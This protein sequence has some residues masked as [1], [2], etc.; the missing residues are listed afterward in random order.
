MHQSES[1]TCKSKWKYYRCSKAEISHHK[2]GG[3]LR[4]LLSSTAHVVVTNLFYK[5]MYFLCNVTVYMDSEE[6]C[7]GSEYS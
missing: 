7:S 1:S 4:Q 3:C 2:W 5:A 6:T